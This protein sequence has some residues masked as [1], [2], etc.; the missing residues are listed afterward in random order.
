MATIN[1][2]P[3]IDKR[4]Q[5]VGAAGHRSWPGGDRDGGGGGWTGPA[6][7]RARRPDAATTPSPASAAVQQP[8]SLP[9]PSESSTRSRRRR[10][11]GEALTGS[12]CGVRVAGDGPCHRDSYGTRSRVSLLFLRWIFKIY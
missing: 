6:G 12:K 9:A 8:S 1:A 4:R 5:A 2:A 3:R 7:R 10:Y 11:H